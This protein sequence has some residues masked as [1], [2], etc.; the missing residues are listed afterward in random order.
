MTGC[1][2]L[3]PPNEKVTKVRETPT[4]PKEKRIPTSFIDDAYYANPKDFFIYLTNKLCTRCIG[5]TV[6]TKDSEVTVIF[7]I[8]K[9]F[10][11]SIIIFVFNLI[12]T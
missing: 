2:L 1:L 7:R 5:N 6:S 3:G 8:Q 11:F 4:G 10:F 9:V 12:T